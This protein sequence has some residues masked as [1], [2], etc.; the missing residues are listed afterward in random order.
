MSDDYTEQ[1]K[2]SKYI[3]Y[4]TFGYIRMNIQILLPT[5]SVYYNIPEGIKHICASYSRLRDEWG[6]CHKEINISNDKT[7]IS[8]DDSDWNTAFGITICEKGNKY[9]WK[10][11]LIKRKGDLGGNTWKTIF[12]VIQESHCKTILSAKQHTFSR[13]F[14]SSGGG[15]GFIG[16]QSRIQSPRQH[17]MYGEKFDTEG[18]TINIILDLRENKNTVSY[19]ING[20]N[21]EKACDVK[22]DCKYRLAVSVCA[23][24]HIKICD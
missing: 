1:I 8:H 22:K 16:Y 4:L 24:R 20:K 18:G 11:K 2:L 12:G 13:N 23:G 19:I 14:T 9:E 5:N 17:K 6:L 10:L 15:Y 7:I 21:Y 3:K